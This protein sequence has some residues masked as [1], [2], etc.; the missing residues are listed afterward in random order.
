MVSAYPTPR[1]PTTGSEATPW[2]ATVWRVKS[3][4]EW[5]EKSAEKRDTSK[6]AKQRVDVLDCNP[7]PVLAYKHWQF[8][9]MLPQVGLQ[10]PPAFYAI[11][12]GRQVEV[13]RHMRLDAESIAAKQAETEALRVAKER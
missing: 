3:R 5:V 10:T 1:V 6:L 9:T 8:P 13:D 12:P 2:I 7:K 11:T 4:V